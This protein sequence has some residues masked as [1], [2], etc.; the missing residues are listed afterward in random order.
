MAKRDKYVVRKQEIREHAV[1][2]RTYSN[3]RISSGEPRNKEDWDRLFRICFENRETDLGR[4]LARHMT[5]DAIR[6]LCQEFRLMGGERGSDES[7]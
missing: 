3:G 2:I 1:Y 5:P 4:L 7:A 6:R